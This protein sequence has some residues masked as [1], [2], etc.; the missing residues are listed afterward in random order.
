VKAQ[1]LAR[2]V[3]VGVLTSNLGCGLPCP[4]GC[5]RYC[6]AGLESMSA[7]SFD[8]VDVDSGLLA[9][10]EASL[11]ARIVAK[12]EAVAACLDSAF[13]VE[14]LP[15][16]VVVAGD[17]RFAEFEGVCIGCLGIKVVDDWTWSADGQWQ[18][19][20][21][22]APKELCAAK[23]LPQG[24][25]QWRAAVQRAEDGRLVAIVGPD[26]RM[27]GDPLVRIMTSCNSVWGV[28]TLARCASITTR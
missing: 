21:L 8:G 18:L 26:L 23:G 14:P 17:C 10:S 11:H 27:L 4:K 3:L 5:E 20:P 6:H 25:C 7:Y 15:H 16:D 2:L 9:D 12:V 19:L 24:S 28:E 1:I 13:G 22:D